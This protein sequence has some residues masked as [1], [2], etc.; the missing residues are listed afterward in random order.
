MRSS[1]ALAGATTATGASPLQAFAH[2]TLT[3]NVAEALA[4]D[5]KVAAKA[6]E[7]PLWVTSSA[8]ICYDN[9]MALTIHLDPETEKRLAETAAARGVTAEALA[10]EALVSWLAID[11]LDWEEDERRMAEPGA[12]IPLDQAFD[13]LE[14][15]IAAKRA[16][17]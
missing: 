14:A 8:K 13:E 10:Q 4:G 9:R 6:R 3:F 1:G 11:E 17:Q 5:L 2:E 7:L 12:N 16:G 15:R